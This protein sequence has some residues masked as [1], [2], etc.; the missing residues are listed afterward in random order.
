MKNS[1]AHYLGLSEGDM[2]MAEEYHKLA[3]SAG[4]GQ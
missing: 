2:K 1:T 4:G 3:K